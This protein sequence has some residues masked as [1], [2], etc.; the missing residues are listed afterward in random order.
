MGLFKITFETSSRIHTV[1]CKK[2]RY[3]EQLITSNTSNRVPCAQRHKICFSQC[4]INRVEQY[5][6][7]FS[8]YRLELFSYDI[9]ER[10]IHRKINSKT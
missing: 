7:L 6:Y 4:M 9:P 1:N 3:M 8:A 10:N 5:I 2:P